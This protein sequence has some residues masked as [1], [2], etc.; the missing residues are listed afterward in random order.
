MI[1]DERYFYTFGTEHFGVSFQQAVNHNDDS[2]EQPIDRLLI[3]PMLFP[4]RI[5]MFPFS[6]FFPCSIYY[7]HHTVSTVHQIHNRQ[8]MLLFL[9]Y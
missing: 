7:I 3:S 4:C 1:F 9:S 2:L 6:Y 8:Q 5:L